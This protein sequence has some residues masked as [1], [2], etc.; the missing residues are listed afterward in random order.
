MSPN[1]PSAQQ[2][3]EKLDALEYA[4]VKAL[5]KAAGVPFTTLWK[6]RSGETSDPRLETVRAIWGE[7]SGAEA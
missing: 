5:S 2:V 6:I 3:R 1:L 7:L 4:Q